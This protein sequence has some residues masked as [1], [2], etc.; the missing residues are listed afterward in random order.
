[1]GRGR[2]KAKQTK[3]ARELKYSSPTMDLDAL[4][5]E[6]ADH[7]AGA[8]LKE[9]GVA[10]LDTS[11]RIEFVEPEGGG[12]ITARNRLLLSGITRRIAARSGVSPPAMMLPSI[13][14]RAGARSRPGTHAGSV[15]GEPPWPSDRWRSQA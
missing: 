9:H 6:R 13:V 1:M 2:A 5:R 14:T 15:A 11:G 7:P 8:Y 10:V 12:V 3:V 4:Q